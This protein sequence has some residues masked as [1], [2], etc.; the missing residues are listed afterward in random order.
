MPSSEDGDGDAIALLPTPSNDS[1]VGTEASTLTATFADGELEVLLH[2]LEEPSGELSVRVKSSLRRNLS[3]DDL[4]A[5]VYSGESIYGHPLSEAE[6]DARMPPGTAGMIHHA[7]VLPDQHFINGKLRGGLNMNEGDFDLDKQQI[8]PRRPSLPIAC[9]DLFSSLTRVH[10]P[11]G[12]TVRYVF[13]G[14]LN[15]WPSL[16]CFELLS[17]ERKR[18]TSSA[19][20]GMLMLPSP[21]DVMMGQTRWTTAWTAEKEGKQG[22]MDPHVA[23]MTAA[24][25]A[26]AASGGASSAGSNAFA[27]TDDSVIVYRAKLRG[28]PWTAR[29][30]TKES[31]GFCFWY[32]AQHPDGPRFTHGTDMLKVLSFDEQCTH[33]HMFNHRYAVKRE[34]P[35]D[36]LTYHSVCLLEWD[37]GQYCTVVEMAFLNGIGGY[38][39]K[40]NW[41]DDLNAQPMTQLYQTL[42][43][44][45]VSPWC[46][47]K[48]EIRCYDIKAK[49]VEEFLQ[50]V[51]KYKG[52]EQRFVDPTVCFVKI[53]MTVFLL[54]SHVAIILF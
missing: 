27:N 8:K 35:R 19:A 50:Y 49:T 3:G 39:G 33:I 38:K 5:Y 40:S 31:P 53:M 28:A 13:Y 51:D 23:V 12:K 46:V 1:S 48:A 45:M 14:V 30:W 52:S 37:H 26:A 29:G 6:A 32:E 25:A 15:G 16:R 10:G 54:R 44:C 4:R 43:A 2:S 24:A 11:D 47:T 18:Q 21:K 20:A 36:Y 17:L 7:T 34:S 9:S 42:P 22:G 41:Y